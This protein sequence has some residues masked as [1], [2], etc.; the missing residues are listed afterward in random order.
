MYSG[1]PLTAG[2]RLRLPGV[3][4]PQLGALPVGSPGWILLSKELSSRCKITM[5]TFHKPHAPVSNL[6]SLPSIRPPACCSTYLLCTS[7]GSPK[8]SSRL[9]SGL[10]ECN[11]TPGVG[12]TP[13]PPAR[14][15]ASTQW[16]PSLMHRGSLALPFS[17]AAWS[18]RRQ[19][20]RRSAAR[21][22]PHLWSQRSCCGMHAS[23]CR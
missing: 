23:C 5:W 8:P 13:S 3:R 4:L 12:P 7:S 11:P 17:S 22:C 21:K 6:G 1:P 19:C 20:R 9:Q 2:G 15:G 16:Q 14:L 10:V 18:E